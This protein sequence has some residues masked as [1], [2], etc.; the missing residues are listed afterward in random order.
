M[1]SL[2]PPSSAGCICP[3]HSIASRLTHERLLLSRHCVEA[4]GGVALYEMCGCA[5]LCYALLCYGLSRLELRQR[6]GAG[7][8]AQRKGAA[9][10]SQGG[11]TGRKGWTPLS[12]FTHIYTHAHTHTHQIAHPVDPI[13]LSEAAAAAAAAA[14]G[15]AGGE[16]TGGTITIDR[17][18]QHA[19]IPCR[20]GS[21]TDQE[22]EE[23]GGRCGCECGAKE[24]EGK[25]GGNRDCDCGWSSARRRRTRCDAFR[26]CSI[27][28]SRDH[29]HSHSQGERQGE[30]QGR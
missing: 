20:R 6:A 13:C 17:Q 27:S 7:H 30:S 9:S 2:L 10:M 8:C 19:V 5:L 22:A 24:G 14:A 16:H 3:S 1:G 15:D 21:S 11:Q 28:S 29:S 25:C 4:A 12:L 23:G 26:R 18:Q